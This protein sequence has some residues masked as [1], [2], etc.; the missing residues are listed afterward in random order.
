MTPTVKDKDNIKDVR[1]FKAIAPL[2]KPISDATHTLSEISFLVLRIQ[3]SSGVTGESYLLS[4]QYSRNAIVGAIKDLQS[5]ACRYTIWETGKF[6]QA[7]AAYHEYFGKTGLLNWATALYNIAMWDAKG[8]ALQLPVHKIFGA[9]RDTVPVYGS[10]GWLSYT[11]DELV[12]E[13]CNYVS[14]GFEAVKIKV[15]SYNWRIDLD[16]LKMV[17]R[18]VG[19]G[20][21]IMMDANQG[22]S[23]PAAC[24]L[25]TAAEDLNIHWFEEPIDHQD[26]DGYK[27]VKDVTR[28]S[29]AMG[30]REF[31][32]LPLKEL[33]R[34]NAIDLWQPDL[35]RI[36]SVEAYR[37]SAALA[38]S[39]HIPVLPHYY[40]DYDVPLLC[41]VAN[42][43]GAESFDWIDQLIDN[44][45]KVKNGHLSPH[46][47][48][49]WGFSFLDEHLHAL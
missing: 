12:E 35:L 20:V 41:S 3:T 13:A 22:M 17:R 25:S 33:I 37:Q 6:N 36:G 28:I 32:T 27:K 29:L 46:D 8:R 19:D 43:M 34:R 23:V 39:H 5:L 11:S 4:F 16:R 30:E 49:G 40:K 18:A 31:D 47:V 48:P 15:G 42:G 38:A 26:F 9:T 10:G 14:R 1:L 45:M 2:R 44:P 7:A 21:K 24:E